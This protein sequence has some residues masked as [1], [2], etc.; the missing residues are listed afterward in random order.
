MEKIERN[1]VTVE[2]KSNHLTAGQIANLISEVL[3]IYKDGGLVEDY[4]FNPVDME[5]NFYAGLF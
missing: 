4:A 1:G 5:I 3:I 2:L